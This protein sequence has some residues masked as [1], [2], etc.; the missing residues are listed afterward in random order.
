MA[1]QKPQSEIK[2]KGCSPEE[3]AQIIPQETILLG[4]RGS[5][6]HGMYL[7]PNDPNSVD[8]KDIMGVCIPPLENYLGLSHF[9]QQDIMLREW[10]SVVYELRKYV[11]LLLNSNPN[12]LGLL[13]LKEQHYIHRSPLGQLLIDNRDLF[14]SKRIYKSF[15]GYAYGQMKRMQHQKKEGYMGE[16]RSALVQKYGYDCKN[17]AHCIRLLRMGIEF[18]ND[19]VLYVF[20]DDA[21]QLMEFK[22]GLWTLAQV[23]READHL[24]KRAED[25]YDRCKLPLEPQTKKV[26]QLLMEMLRMH[27]NM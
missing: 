4:Y 26:E 5:I 1:K 11:R 16:K 21:P 10:D 3:V 17:A 19:G 24:F 18:L 13:W 23:Q 7:N 20:R 14:V 8:D 15:T 6:A 22:M 27:F 25:A 9:E 2:L 12:V